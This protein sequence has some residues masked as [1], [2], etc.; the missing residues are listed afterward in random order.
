MDAYLALHTQAFEYNGTD[1]KE[2]VVSK[3]SRLLDDMRDIVY[4]YS[5]ENHFMPSSSFADVCVFK[6]ENILEFVNHNFG[7]EEAGVFYSMLDMSNE[8]TDTYQELFEKTKFAPDEKEVYSLVILNEQENAES[9]TKSDCLM[10]FDNYQIVYN[11]ISWLCLRRQILGNHPGSEQEFIEECR[12]YFPNI[13][14]HDN[15]VTSLKKANYL[16]VIPCKIV[17]YLSCLNDGFLLVRDEHAGIANDANSILRDFSGRFALDEAGSLQGNPATK[18][19]RKFGGIE[20]E[21]HLKIERVDERCR[22][23]GLCDEKHFHSRIYFCFSNTDKFSTPLFV[24]SIGPH[25]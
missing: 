15:C 17:Y 23:K 1:A 8:C 13:T 12:K 25:L 9:E 10:Q 14:F 16:E 21:P 19:D 20:C 6:D 24:G 22:N 3:M 2:T 7:Y 11:R 5:K 18:K 4:Q